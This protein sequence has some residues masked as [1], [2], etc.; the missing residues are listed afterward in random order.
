MSS[1]TGHTLDVSAGGARFELPGLRTPPEAGSRLY[2]ELTLPGDELAPAVVE[3]V[4][5][6]AP[7]RCGSSTWPHWIA[8][9]WPVWSS[10][11][12]GGCS[13]SAAAA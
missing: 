8:T 13:P 3:V 11:R 10:R 1:Q 2:A 6:A 7:C 9:G 4:R 12:S 5:Y